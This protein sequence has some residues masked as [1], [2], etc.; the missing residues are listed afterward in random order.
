MLILISFHLCFLLNAISKER[1]LAISVSSCLHISQVVI[2][3]MFAFFI[4]FLNK[5]LIVQ[6]NFV[7]F[8]ISFASWSFFHYD[9]KV[10]SGVVCLEAI[11]IFSTV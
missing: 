6:K 3:C 4:D 2:G 9:L 8:L 11:L 7:K 1:S 10:K 5:Y